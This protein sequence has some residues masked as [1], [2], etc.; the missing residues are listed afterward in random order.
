[1]PIVIPVIGASEG[2]SSE[3]LFASRGSMD[4]VN[5]PAYTARESIDI[6][7]IGT[8][9]ARESI[10]VT[11]TRPVAARASMSVE[12]FFTNRTTRTVDVV[13][14]DSFTILAYIL[15]SELAGSS[16][17]S[18]GQLELDAELRVNDSVVPIKSFSFQVPTGRL[19]SLLN[20]VLADPEVTSIPAGASVKFQLIVTLGG[21]EYPYVLMDNG[22]LQE[23]ASQ[24]K[25]KGGAQDGPQDEV[26]FGALDVLADKFTLAPRRPVV[27][28]DPARVKYDEVSTNAQDAVLD[29][30]GHIIYPV[31][32]PV[33]GLKMKQ[34]LS[35]AYTTAGGLMYASALTPGFLSGITWGTLRVSSANNQNGCGFSAVITNVPNY[36]VRR[37]DF[38]ITGGWHDGAQPCV[39]MYSPLYFVVGTKLFIIDVDRTLPYGISAHTITLADHKTLTER[40]PFKPDTNAVLLTYQYSPNDPAEDAGRLVREV[41]TETVDETEGVDPGDSGYSKV[42]TRRW[43]YEYYLATEPTNVLASYPKSI[44]VETVQTVE[45]GVLS[46]GDVT[47]TG[48][49]LMATHQ[50]TTDYTYEGEL[51]INTRKIVKGIINVGASASTDLIDI[52]RED[53][54]VT[55]IDDPYNPGVKIQDRV[56]TD[57]K[58]LI[59]YSDTNEAM[60][61]P[62]GEVSD[63]VRGYPLLQAQASSLVTVDS[64]LSTGLLPVKSIRSTLHRL[65]GNQFNVSTVEIDY[66]NNTV[67]RS[68]S[69]PTT[70]TNSTNQ[71][72]QK[73]RTVMFRDLTSEAEIGPRIPVSINS[74]ELPRALA[75]ALARRTLQR[76]KDPLQQMPIDLPGVDFTIARGSI[77]RGQRRDGSYTNNFFVTGYSIT[78]SNL[79]KQGHRIA[80]SLETI[81]MLTP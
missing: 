5:A 23:R 36:P 31:I 33:Y 25:W 51:L 61:G 13:S 14:G 71:F 45:F 27:M 81:E 37:A 78:G 17:G 54:H 11:A 43:D 70:G 56:I 1:M 74:Y 55:W 38:T 34:I 10:V 41:F 69:Q 77:V 72:G 47:V 7:S 64:I 53:T 52:E 40:V 20:V 19:G 75:Y 2:P 48:Q 3:V 50:E 28:Y 6:T 29:E 32:E 21:V 68:Y 18:Y 79:G 66:L 16:L 24:V 22:K 73:S 4:V 35:R 76:I 8:Y 63:A 46:G 80:Q 49:G 30:T 12:N 15:A 60:L 26:T 42:T 65:N 39:A 44:E 59:L 58:S 67:K 62:A 9:G 57:I